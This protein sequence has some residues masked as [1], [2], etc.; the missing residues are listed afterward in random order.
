MKNSPTGKSPFDNIHPEV[1]IDT[2][3]TLFGKNLIQTTCE[4][5]V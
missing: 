1:E 3:D 5:F 4:D 2:S